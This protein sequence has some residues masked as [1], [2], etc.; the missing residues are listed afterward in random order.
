[1]IFCSQIVDEISLL[2]V[3]FMQKKAPA[4][5]ACNTGIE[6]NEIIRK[7]NKNSFGG[8]L[9]PLHIINLFLYIRSNYGRVTQKNSP[10]SSFLWL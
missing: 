10:Y 6:K 5:L 4:Q 7:I 1:M 8:Y 9:L 2:A 3:I